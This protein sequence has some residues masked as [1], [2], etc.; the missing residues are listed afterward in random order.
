MTLKAI[1]YVITFEKKIDFLEWPRS[2]F[3]IYCPIRKLLS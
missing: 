1:K 3:K 2:Y